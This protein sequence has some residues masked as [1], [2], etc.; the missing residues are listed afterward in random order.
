MSLTLQLRLPVR[1]LTS[2]EP[3][4]W[5]QWQEMDD[6]GSSVVKANPSVKSDAMEKLRAYMHSPKE[7]VKGNHT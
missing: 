3:G 4:G 1:R 6:D 5:L 2:T 7:G